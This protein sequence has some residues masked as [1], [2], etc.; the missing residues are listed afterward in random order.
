[1]PPTGCSNDETEL[2]RWLSSEMSDPPSLSSFYRTPVVDRIE[3][4]LTATCLWWH[5]CTQAHNTHTHTHTNPS[6]GLSLTMSQVPFFSPPKIPMAHQSDK[7]FS[8]QTRSSSPLTASRWPRALLPHHLSMERLAQAPFLQNNPHRPGPQQGWLSLA[9]AKDNSL[10]G[11]GSRGGCQCSPGP[12]QA[13][14]GT[15]Q[16][17]GRSCTI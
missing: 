10:S 11:A 12:Q 17:G 8:R 9:S 1:M 3:S 16:A 4:P 13:A 7:S 14:T 6:H 5:V 15:A 2:E